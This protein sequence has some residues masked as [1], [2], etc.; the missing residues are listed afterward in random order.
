VEATPYS[1]LSPQQVVV[2]V[3]RMI[4]VELEQMAVLVAVGQFILKRAEQELLVKALLVEQ[5][6]HLLRILAV[7][8][9]AL[10]LL[11]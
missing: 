10:G 4:K 9:A 1:V 5:A 7:A 8:V 11:V 2:V 6:L 3:D